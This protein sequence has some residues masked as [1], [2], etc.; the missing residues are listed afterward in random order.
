MR[1]YI[2]PSTEVLQISAYAMQATQTGSAG[3]DQDLGQAPKRKL[4]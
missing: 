1:N 2:I 3:G 4:F